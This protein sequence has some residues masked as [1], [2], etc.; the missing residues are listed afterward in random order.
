MGDL[1][2]YD[3]WARSYRQ[4]RRQTLRSCARRMALDALTVWP[5]RGARL[6]AWDDT[7]RV[8]I[9][10]LH[11]VFEDEQAAFDRLVAHL[12]QHFRLVPYSTAVHRLQSGNVTEPLL[13]FTFDDGFKNCLTAARILEA[14]DTRGCFFVCPRFVGQQHLQQLRRIC[15]ER[16]AM[17][18]TELMTWDDLELLVDRGHEVCAHT[19]THPYLHQLTVEQAAREISQSRE[20]LLHRLGIAD[21]FAWPYGGFH[22]LRAEIA[23]EVMRAGFRTCASGER[24]A[25]AALP[26]AGHRFCLRRDSLVAGWPL[27]HVEYFLARS[28]SRL[29]RPEQTWPPAWHAALPS[30]AIEP[31]PAA[32][33]A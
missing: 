30:P 14:Y 31:T 1:A 10:V 2:V 26:T 12:A 29:L 25:H 28:A 32:R 24:G 13:A 4:V 7:P 23:A 3:E 16:W 27:R 11:H 20:A 15:L 21:H 18:P 5:R 6:T 9:L 22:H 33:A 19:M 17:P 8:Q